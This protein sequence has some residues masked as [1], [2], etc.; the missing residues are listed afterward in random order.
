M[1]TVMGNL[2]H[3]KHYWTFIDTQYIFNENKYIHRKD[4]WSIKTSNGKKNIYSIK[5]N[6]ANFLK[7]LLF[8][9]TCI[10]CV[11]L[12]MGTCMRTQVPSE[13]EELE[14]QAVVDAQYGCYEL[15]LAPLEE[16]QVS[17]V[18]NTEPSFQP[19]TVSTSKVQSLNL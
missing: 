17:S 1:R 14:L 8:S 18:L 4:K 5:L 9:F 3:A 15:Y 11:Y 10:C 13:P 19:Q 12:R 2:K 6:M 16:H 7:R